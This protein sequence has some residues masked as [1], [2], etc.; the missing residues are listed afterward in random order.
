MACGCGCENNGYDTKELR[1][2]Y[3]AGFRAGYEA[4]RNEANDGGHGNGTHNCGCNRR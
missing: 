2:A 4:G 3:R 1:E